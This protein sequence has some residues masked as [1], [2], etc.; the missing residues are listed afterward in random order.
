MAAQFV[1]FFKC[2]YFVVSSLQIKARYPDYNV[3]W[4]L[5]IDYA[6]PKQQFATIKSAIFN[7]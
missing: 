7:V 6:K 4:F 3:R 5:D 2:A 1:Y